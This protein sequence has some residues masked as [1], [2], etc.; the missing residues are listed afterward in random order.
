M[1]ESDCLVECV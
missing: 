1:T